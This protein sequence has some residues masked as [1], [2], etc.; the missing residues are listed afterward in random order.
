MEEFRKSSSRKSRK[1]DRQTNE[2]VK[3]QYEEMNKSGSSKNQCENAKKCAEEKAKSDSEIAVG[4]SVIAKKSAVER[5]Q[6]DIKETNKETDENVTKAKLKNDQKVEVAK[7]PTMST[8]GTPLRKQFDNKPSEEIVFKV[9]D[10]ISKSQPMS[11]KNQELYTSLLKPIPAKVGSLKRRFMR[12]V[13]LIGNFYACKFCGW[14]FERKID[15][16]KH[17][18]SNHANFWKGTILQKSPDKGKNNVVEKYQSIDRRTS[19]DSEMDESEGNITNNY[20][21]ETNLNNDETARNKLVEKP[22]LTVDNSTSDNCE[23]PSA[24]LGRMAVKSLIEDHRCL[25]CG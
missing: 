17:M 16:V 14:K 5:A 6:N 2:T 25:I 11:I 3:E 4:A 12:M 8:I 1:N 20:A 21:T 10:Q 24:V 9:K 18:T 7:K 13:P 19:I 23:V 22:S 15:F